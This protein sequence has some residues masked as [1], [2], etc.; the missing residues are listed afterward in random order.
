MAAPESDRNSNQDE[1]PG[2]PGFRSWPALY[3]FVIVV[4]V[5]TVVGLAVFSR[6]YA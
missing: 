5:L 4:F 1:V 6:I 2:V 3:V